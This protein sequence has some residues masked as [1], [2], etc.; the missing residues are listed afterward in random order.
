MREGREKKKARVILTFEKFAC[1]GEE[2]ASNRKVAEK[3]QR[4]LVALL[5]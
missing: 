3:R 2:D 4:W 1:E 5:V